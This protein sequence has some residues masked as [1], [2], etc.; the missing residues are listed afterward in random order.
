MQLG[1]QAQSPTVDQ[2]C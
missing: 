2:S 1:G